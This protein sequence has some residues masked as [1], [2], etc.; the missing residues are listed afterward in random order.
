V[1]LDTSDVADLQHRV[2]RLMRY[3]AQTAILPRL[4]QLQHAEIIEK[5]P[6]ELVT[7]A[8]R[9]SEQILTEG[10]LAIL[11]EA[12]VVGEEA[13]EADPTLLERMDEGLVWIVDPLDGT[14]N[15]AGGMA[16]F[17]IIV[18]LAERGEVVAA[19]LHDPLGDRMCFAALGAGAWMSRGDGT[20]DR[21]NVSVPS[22]RPIA[23]L[24]TQFMPAH[25]RESVLQVAAGVFELQPIPR[26]AAEH[27]PRLC[28]GEN[29]VALFQRTLPWDH[30]AG[31]LLLTEAGGH[32][33]RWSGQPYNFHDDGVGILAATSVE[34]WQRAADVLLSD[35]ALNA[36]A[37]ALLPQYLEPRL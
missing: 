21:L 22:G 26:C 25:V 27:Y 7:V 19:L 34:L 31:A 20:P 12:R 28:L 6:G 18:A 24:A 1:S 35:G 10:L 11:P 13:C 33:A 8:D 4:G 3:A 30:A 36:H 14:A 23:S 15:F 17:G 2:S 9:E 29:H 16:P 37:R 32:V 5:T